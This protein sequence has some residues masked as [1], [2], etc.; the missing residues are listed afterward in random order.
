[1][2]VSGTW[3]EEKESES[4]ESLCEARLCALNEGQDIWNWSISLERFRQIDIN[5]NDLRWLVCKGFVEHRRE[6]TQPDDERRRFRRS[7]GLVFDEQT[8]FVVTEEGVRHAQ[9]LND[10]T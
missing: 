10:A 9:R 1:M 6:T 7:Q 2:S 3:K 8:C 4:L 5:A